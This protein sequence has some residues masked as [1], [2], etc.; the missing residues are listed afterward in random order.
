MCGARGSPE[1]HSKTHDAVQAVLRR[2]YDDRVRVVFGL[3]F[4]GCTPEG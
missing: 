1:G 4:G 3:T 2:R